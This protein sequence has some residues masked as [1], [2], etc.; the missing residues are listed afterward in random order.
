MNTKRTYIV[1]VSGGVDS[2][3][4]LDML[5]KM[6]DF[7]LVVAH[8][9]HG[10]RNDSHDDAAFVKELAVQYG[11]TYEAERA[12]LG[13]QASEETARKARYAFLRNVAQR[14]D[15]QIVTAHHADDALETIIINILRGTGWRGLASLRST[16]EIARPLLSYRKTQLVTYAKNHHLQ[17][18]EDSTN[19]ETKYFRNTI[20][21][22]I[23]PKLGEQTENILLE[24][25]KRQVAVRQELEEVT[26]EVLA[27]VRQPS[28]AY[29][30]HE[31]IMN[32]PAVA[33][34]ILYEL[35]RHETGS[36][37]MQS[38]L[39]ASLLA[40]KTAHTNTRHQVGDGVSLF[41]DKQ[42]FKVFK[43]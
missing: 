18:R 12:E 26:D 1:A 4:L 42:S 11:L 34:E 17:W 39:D 15:G 5:V 25:Y 37:T 20:R 8:F 29:R 24:L 27:R 22:T 43:M 28:G 31:F 23:I 30:R 21:H 35:L 40:I 38:R 19:S 16:A 36:G 32:E 13:E 7:R 6:S 33:S 41:F 14:Y 2:V 9:D 10:I 3:V